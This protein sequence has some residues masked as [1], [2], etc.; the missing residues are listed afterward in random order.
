MQAGGAP[1]SK[2]LRWADQ[3]APAEGFTIGASMQQVETL[4]QPCAKPSRKPLLTGYAA[5]VDTYFLAVY[6]W[7]SW[8]IQDVICVLQL[9]RNTYLLCI[10]GF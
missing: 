4:R 2:V 3:V 5:L 7:E 1:S 8:P 9:L 6:T 10:P